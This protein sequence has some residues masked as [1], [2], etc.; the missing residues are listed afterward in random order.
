M[1]A[2]NEYQHI[3]MASVE[4]SADELTQILQQEDIGRRMQTNHPLATVQEWAIGE[5][6][7]TIEQARFYYS[8]LNYS[9]ALCLAKEALASFKWATAEEQEKDAEALMKAIQDDVESDAA[10]KKKQAEEDAKK[11]NADEVNHKF[12]SYVMYNSGTLRDLFREIDDD[13]SGL[14]NAKE[15]RKVLEKL[16]LSMATVEFKKLYRRYDPDG[17]GIS[18]NEFLHSVAMF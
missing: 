12:K 16:D 18:Y 6:N 3:G 17:D 8:S 14:L 15:F 9:K 5:A 11:P 4:R 13:G 7:H 1:G 10:A 2:S